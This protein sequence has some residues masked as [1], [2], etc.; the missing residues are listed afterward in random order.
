MN[1]TQNHE[2]SPNDELGEVVFSGIPFLGLQAANAASLFGSIVAGSALP[3]IVLELSGSP[4][5]MGITAIVGMIPLLFGMVFAGTIVDRLGYRRASVL[6]DLGNAL[7]LAA[8]PLLY[9]T[10]NAPLLFLLILI[11]ISSLMAL[12]GATAREALLPPVAYR[13][14]LPLERANAV[15]EMIQ[16]LVFMAGPVAAGLVVANLGPS[17][18]LWLNAAAFMLSALVI[19][20]TQPDRLGRRPQQLDF[21]Q[22]WMEGVRFLRQDRVIWLLVLL[23]ALIILLGTPLVDL[24]SPMYTQGLQA[25]TDEPFDLTSFL[26]MQAAGTVFGAMLYGFLATRMKQRRLLGDGLIAAGITYFAF[27]NLP[28]LPVLLVNAFFIGMVLGLMNPL[29]TTAIQQRTPPALRGRIFAIVVGFSLIAAPMG[30][31]VGNL[32]LNQI[33]VQPALFAIAICF[34][35][36]A[37]GVLKLRLRGATEVLEEG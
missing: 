23:S 1:S 8:M 6:A 11:F 24:V 7:T 28:P 17:S 10:F 25:L 30:L 27:A 35:V 33:G 22:E 20:A 12:P 3:F 13:A 9:L 29:L 34:F 19:L 31:L 5:A 26:G 2:L 37:G 32:V 18:A 15:A 21:F 4:A 14:Q 16:G 36:V